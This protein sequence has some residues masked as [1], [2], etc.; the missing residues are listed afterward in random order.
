MLLQQ[1]DSGNTC[2]TD[3]RCLQAGTRT[4]LKNPQGEFT[5]E[6]HYLDAQ[7]LLEDSFR[8]GMRVLESGY[9]PTFILAVWRGG[10][11][12]GIAI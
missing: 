5:L 1:A 6:K 11:P 2:Q 4:P 9:R 3:Q 12:M 10:A 8:L 7:Q